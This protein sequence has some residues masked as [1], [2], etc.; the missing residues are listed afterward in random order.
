MAHCDFYHQG[1]FQSDLNHGEPLY[2]AEALCADERFCFC[3]EHPSSSSEEEDDGHGNG[4]GAA[5]APPDWGP[6]W[7]SNIMMSD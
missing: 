2:F 3:F 6:G 1:L 5:P 7:D 4:T